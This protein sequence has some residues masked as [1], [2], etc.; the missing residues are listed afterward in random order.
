MAQT[1]APSETRPAAWRGY[2]LACDAAHAGRLAPGPVLVW[3]TLS[4]L[5]L[6]AAALIATWPQWQRAEHEMAALVVIASQ[7]AHPRVQEVLPHAEALASALG[8]GA[9]ASVLAWIAAAAFPAVPVRRAADRAASGLRTTLGQSLTRSPLVHPRRGPQGAVWYVATLTAGSAILAATVVAALLTTTAPAA[10][11]HVRGSTL[12]IVEP[13]VWSMAVTLCVVSAVI[14]TLVPLGRAVALTQTGPGSHGGGTAQ[15]AC[16]PDMTGPRVADTSASDPEAQRSPARS[17]AVTLVTAALGLSAA[18]LA[19]MYAVEAMLARP[20]AD[21]YRYFAVIRQLG[22]THFL[23]HHLDTESGRYSQGLLV[24]SAYRI[25]GLASVQWMPIFYLAFLVLTT[26]A[27]LRAFIPVF[28][29]LPYLTALAAGGAAVM[30]AIVAA[31]SVVDSYLW[32]TSSTVYVPEIPMLMAAALALRAAMQRQPP[33]RRNAFAA[34][35]VV[36][37]FVAQGFYEASSLLAAGAAAALLVAMLARRDARNV[38]LAAAVTLAALAGLAVMYFA[39]GERIR[40]AAAGGGNVLVGALGAAYGQLQ[41]WQSFGAGQWLLILALGL[42]L[43]ALLARRT[44]ARAVLRMLVTG[45]ILLVAVPAAC[46]FVSFYSLNWAPWRTYTLSAAAFCWGSAMVVGAVT[47]LLSRRLA[48]TR[49]LSVLIAVA[50]FAG[51]IA[52][53]PAGSAVV[54]AEAKRASMMD[55]RDALVQEQLRAGKPDVLVYPAPLLYYPTDARDFE[56]TATQNKAWFGPGYRAYFGIPP[57]DKLEFVT[58]P[59]PGYCTDDPRIADG[60]PLTCR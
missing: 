6:Q 43:G 7:Q 52:L 40:A 34:V 33:G 12:T 18:A 19:A 16:E 44:P 50:A 21:D 5:L 30:L 26:A 49:A 17:K 13:T 24:W 23:A 39:P 47:A 58:H 41:L 51:V 48:G 59:P 27:T 8:T 45:G 15:A 35:A 20:I 10:T 53:V 42:G 29:G 38:I 4:G 56:F 2:E 32:L 1:L 54:S 28:R 46:S 3:G 9:A 60:S 57:T 55:Y 25:G 14:A 36:L 22:V 37:V 31:P 11:V